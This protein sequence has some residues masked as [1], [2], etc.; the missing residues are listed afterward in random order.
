MNIII[1]QL[2][3]RLGINNFDE[4]MGNLSGGQRRKADL[5]RVLAA[6]PDL[7]LFR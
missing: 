1:N 3:S 4:K 2:T 7:L 5:A 6:E